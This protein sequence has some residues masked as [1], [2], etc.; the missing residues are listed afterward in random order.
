MAN[1]CV[2]RLG[3]CTCVRQ[4]L[5]MFTSPV[6]NPTFLTCIFVI[7]PCKALVVLAL[8]KP[9]SAKIVLP[10]ATFEVSQ[11][12]IIVVYNSRKHKMVTI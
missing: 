5:E 12:N 1:L 11:L 2:E 6:L 7:P 8:L 4:V 10:R 9:N 3:V